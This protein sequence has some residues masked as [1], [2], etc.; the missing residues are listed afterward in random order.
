[1][2]NST[3]AIFGGSFNPPH[4]GHV[5]AAAYVLSVHEVDRLLVVPTYRHAFNKELCPFEHRLEMARLAFGELAR[6]EICDIEREL[7][8]EVSRTLDTLEALQARRPEWSLR[9]VVGADVLHD[10]DKWYRFERVQELAPLL[11]LGRAGVAHPDAPPSVLPEVSSSAVRAA[12]QS[13][14][15]AWVRAYVP[16]AVRRYIRQERIYGV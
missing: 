8:R 9:L 12:L 15:D 16:A 10:R 14:D 3:V 7:G 11:V 13:G 6:A 5:L 1:M 4:V 2:G